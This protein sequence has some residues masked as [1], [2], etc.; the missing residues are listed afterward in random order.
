MSSGTNVWCSAMYTYLS[1]AA[2][3]AKPPRRR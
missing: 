1:I 2:A 3:T